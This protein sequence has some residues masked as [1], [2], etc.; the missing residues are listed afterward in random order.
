MSKPIHSAQSKRLRRLLVDHRKRSGL[1]Q[2][3]LAS[4]IG[5]PQTFVSKVETGERRMDVIELLQI[6]SAL[7]ADPIE[8]IAALLRRKN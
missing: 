1:T 8:F 6:L 4:L 2:T 7:G 5:R 3:E